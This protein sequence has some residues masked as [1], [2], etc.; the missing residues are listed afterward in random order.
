MIPRFNRRFVNAFPV[1][2]FSAIG[3]GSIGGKAE[4]LR[5]A[6]ELLTTRLDRAAFPQFTIEI[7]TLTVLK[8]DLF[9][10][11]MA[12]NDL[13]KLV[14]SEDRDD[15]IALA[16]QKAGLPADVVGDLRAI[17]EQVRT[18]LAVR[19]SSL[20]EDSLAQPFAGVYETKMVP[21]NQPD[22]D[23]RFRRLVEAIK[24]VYASTFFARARQYRAAAGEV[25]NTEKMAVVVQEVTG[26]RH[27]DR[28]YPDLSGVARS[29]NFYPTGSARQDEGIVILALGLGKT[30]VDGG[31][32]WS[33]SPSRPRATPP[34]GSIDEMLERT[35]T[36]F[37]AVNMGKPPTYDPIAETEYLIEC[38]LGVAE[39]NGT[40]RYA[41]STYDARS[42]RLVAGCAIPGPRVLTFAPLLVLEEAPI[43]R[44]VRSLLDTCATAVGQP[45]E[46]EF[47]ATFESAPHLIVRFGFLQVRP[48]IV[49]HTSVEI[50]SEEMSGPDVLLSSDAALGNGTIEDIL[51]I[52][53]V[54]PDAFEARHTPTIARDIAA[55]NG[56]LTSA[57][58]PYLL[59]GFGRWGSSDPWLGVPVSWG[60]IGGARAIVEAAGPSL[61]V[62]ASQ[63]SHFFHNLSSFQVVYFSPPR[64]R[65]Q[66]VDWNWLE[67]QAPAAEMP[68]VRHVRLSRPLRIR[69]DGRTG[70]GLVLKPD[71]A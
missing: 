2:R 67:A 63:G 27:R 46:I 24:L 26:R 38:D 37:W 50:A 65:G 52:V 32:A 17:V 5:L 68:L 8:T 48:M 22:L 16:F 21:N 61:T 56:A 39:E 35:Q 13:W 57:R 7:P 34:F 19:S 41:A 58:R 45:A 3:D 53:Y 54:R 36:R 71:A 31:V 25:G 66:G 64:G 69:V 51:D 4:G 1:E 62:E 14:A 10:R 49:S 18:P 23:S 15:R 33:Y 12:Q 30:I 60:Q 55:L 9:D 6:H 47:A 42:D 20:L 44:L 11:F 43:N 70:R 28:Y 59:I 40:L 29:Y